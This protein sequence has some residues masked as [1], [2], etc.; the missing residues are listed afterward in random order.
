MC[1]CTPRFEAL[2]HI[3]FHVCT[4]VYYDMCVCLHMSIDMHVNTSLSAGS[5]CTFQD[6]YMRACMRTCT[7]VYAT[8]AVVD[9]V[10]LYEE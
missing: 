4:C 2:E 8:A 1:E 3:Y 10:Q 6:A 7:C 9:R 5:Q